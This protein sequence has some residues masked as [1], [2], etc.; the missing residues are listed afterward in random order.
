MLALQFTITI[1]AHLNN[2]AYETFNLQYVDHFSTR[3]WVIPTFGIV[4]K[5]LE[6]LDFNLVNIEKYQFPETPP[7]TYLTP[8][9]VNLSLSYAKKDQ[10]DPS[11]Y[12]LQNVVKN[13]LRDH[14]FIWTDGS[15]AVAVIDDYSSIERLAL[16]WVET[17]DDDERKFIIFSDSKSSLQVILG[18]DWTHPLVLKILERIHWPV[19]YQEKRILI[20]WIPSHIGIRGNENADSAAK[21]GLLRRVTYETQMAGWVGWGHQQQITCKE[22]LEL[23][24]VGKVF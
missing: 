5:S 22:V 17:A 1:A 11:I 24:G 13:S 16:E 14:D 19:Q 23:L 20:Y 8:K 9:F 21:A 2:P 6:E 10:M 3:L 18:W 7:W 15:S 12:C 4:L